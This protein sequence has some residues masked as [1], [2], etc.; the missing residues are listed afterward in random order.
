MSAA[1]QAPEA[2]AKASGRVADRA[3]LAGVVVALVL[4]GVAQ[5]S[6]RGDA[7]E[8]AVW[9]DG[10]LV[11]AAVAAA[12]LL[13]RPRPPTQQSAPLLDRPRRDFV[14]AVLA[15]TGFAL[16]AVGA[17]TLADDWYGSFTTAAPLA[18]LGVAVWSA[19]LAVRDRRRRPH[20]RRGVTRW[21]AVLLLVVVAVGFFMRFHRFDYYPPPDGV[22]AVEEPQAGQHTFLV[23]EHGDRPWEF[24]GDRWLPIPT[25]HT[26]GRSL[27]TLRLPFALVSAL[28]VI[29]VYLLLRSVVS[30]PVALFATALSAVCSWNLVYARLAHN[31]FATNLV[32]VAVLAMCARVH[33]RGGLT[34]YPWIGFLSGY[35]LYTYAGYR[36]TGLLVG[37]FLVLSFAAGVRRW[38]SS[39]AGPGRVRARGL[40]GTQAV[41]LILAVLGLAVALVPLGGRL[42][43]NPT[44]FF[45]A[46]ERSTL[47]NPTFRG[48]TVESTLGRVRARF[49]ETALMFNHVGDGSET[50]N[51]PGEPMLDP[52]IAVLFAVSAAYCLFFWRHRWQGYFAF[53]FLFLLLMGTTF[54][55][56]FDVRRLQGIIPFI[57][58]LIALTAE[59][60]KEL[61]ERS[62]ATAARP[63]L[64]VVAVAVAGSA[65]VVNYD[66]FFR[67]MVEDPRVRVAFQNRYTVGLRYMRAMPPGDFLFFVT[68][69]ANVFMPSD[70]QWLLRED[71]PA[72]VATDLWPLFSGQ[73]REWGAGELHVLVQDPYDRPGIA[74]LL[75]DRFRG[76]RCEDVAHPDKPPRVMLTACRIPLPLRQ[77]PF[78]GGVR[79]RYYLGNERHPVVVRDEPVISFAFLPEICRFPAGRPERPCR[80]E[81]E[82]DWVVPEEGAY[83]VF[84]EVRHGS[85]SVTIDGNP[86]PVDG[87]AGVYQKA[88][89]QLPLSAGVHRIRVEARFNA[90]EENGARLRV[91]RVG[92]ASEDLLMF[93]N[94]VE[95]PAARSS[96]SR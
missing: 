68:D 25:F 56:N 63:M 7:V 20:T 76:T 1:L 74:R 62:F 69:A 34:W 41:G 27:T 65:F 54:V 33:V 77:R 28:T 55:Q 12:L 14:G 80:A 43:R 42:Q 94:F 35:T 81:W 95:A 47:V 29:A 70:F 19:G 92:S 26:L 53:A 5:W 96:L 61:T 86:V 88:T 57:F 17:R 36:G 2:S 22:C 9:A 8:A 16:A 13:G 90:I 73:R 46:V 93:R 39:E 91:A 84:A 48:E 40:V 21:E 82:G 59:R 75:G 18:V 44:Y 24:V 51:L 60:F 32:V 78:P 58:V 45:E 72:Q 64:I 79:A 4:C 83:R 89:A 85:F 71:V 52:L 3:R 15:L 49:T 31:I 10:V 67:R 50:F 37:L 66:M 38:W 30:V 6:I 87:P 23:M 11:G